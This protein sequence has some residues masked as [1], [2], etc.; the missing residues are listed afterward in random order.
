MPTNKFLLTA[1]GRQKLEEELR[2]LKQVRRPEVIERIQEAV[3]HGDLSENT[4]YAQAKEEQAFIEGRIAE[5]EEILKHAEILD[6]AKHKIGGTVTL[7]SRVTIQ[8]DGRTAE[9]TIVGRSEANPAEGRISN[10][11]LVGKAL[12]GA[13]IGEKVKVTTPAG[14]KEYEI[15]SVE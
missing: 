11:S 12:L 15:V 10:E 13:K 3:A 5:I 9:Y 6:P 14:E 2:V 1:A 4:D 8:I 7:G